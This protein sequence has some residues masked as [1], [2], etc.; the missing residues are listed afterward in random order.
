MDMKNLM[1]VTSQLE[2]SNINYALGS[3]GML[4]SLGL[5]DNVNDWDIMTDAPKEQILKA[6][7]P[8][9]IK[10]TTGAEYPFGT[11]YKLAIHENDPQVEILGNFAIFS[12]Q[13]LCKMPTWAT[14]TWQGVQVSAPEVWFVAYS[15]MERTSKADLLLDYLKSQPANREVIKLLMKQPLPQFIAQQ[16]EVIMQK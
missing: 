15:L 2:S 6:L 12:D 1:L 8:F 9:T 13:Y 7:Q 5:T 3:S 16:L 11:E 14:A 10:E 4:L